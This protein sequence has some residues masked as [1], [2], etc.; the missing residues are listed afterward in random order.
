LW[1]AYR[2]NV[3]I[4]I[5]FINAGLSLG[6]WLGTPCIRTQL[7]WGEFLHREASP[8][9]V[10]FWRQLLGTITPSSNLIAEN[11]HSA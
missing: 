2:L 5:D 9:T 10:A 8:D 11:V 4:E 7:D 1:I 3:G 6:T